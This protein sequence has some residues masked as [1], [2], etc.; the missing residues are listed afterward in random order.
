[1]IL[2]RA[3]AVRHYPEAAHQALGA[4]I[5]VAYH[6]LRVIVGEDIGPHMVLPRPPKR[7]QDDVG[8]AT[9][10]SK[11][12]PVKMARRPNPAVPPALQH[13]MHSASESRS[14]KSEEHDMLGWKAFPDAPGDAR[15]KH[16]SFGQMNVADLLRAVEEGRVKIKPS[17][18]EKARM[19][20]TGSKA[21][22]ASRAADPEQAEVPTEPNT[23][24]TRNTVPTEPMTSLS[25]EGPEDVPETASED[26]SS[27]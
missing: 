26:S 18:S 13:L 22:H 27:S 4:H 5:G 14:S 12:K 1:M 2:S 9:S 20:P 24:L 3:D 11:S 8:S 17:T 19:S 16:G 23:N 10:K 6:K 21:S 7:Q 15:S 25:N